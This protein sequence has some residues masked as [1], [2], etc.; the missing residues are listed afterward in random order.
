MLAPSPWNFPPYLNV[1]SIKGCPHHCRFE[2]LMIWTMHWCN[3]MLEQWGWSPGGK[4]A[5][6]NR[7]MSNLSIK[8]KLQYTFKRTAGTATL[9]S[10]YMIQS[11]NLHRTLKVGNHLENVDIHWHDS[12]TANNVYVLTSPLKQPSVHLGTWSLV[13]NFCSS[14]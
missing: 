14:L 11:P 8:M 9:H 4:C 7:L 6:T 1:F 12:Q 10:K 2:R 3:M 13:A 5:L